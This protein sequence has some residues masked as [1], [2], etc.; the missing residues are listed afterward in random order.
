MLIF[1][2]FFSLLSFQ[3]VAHNEFRI[4]AIVI[5]SNSGFAILL[6][7]TANS[8]MNLIDII[9]F[10]SLYKIPKSIAR[11]VTSSRLSL[12]QH[13]QMLNIFHRLTETIYFWFTFSSV[14]FNSNIF[15]VALNFSKQMF[16]VW[17]C[18]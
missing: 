8:W 13:S 18:V 11:V 9:W 16:V 14:H 3:H 2:V 4:K 7:S 1:M 15:L 6:L 5:V 12:L 17:K 10:S